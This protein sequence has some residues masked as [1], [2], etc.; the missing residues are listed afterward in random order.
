MKLHN[1]FGIKQTRCT[2]SVPVYMGLVGMEKQNSWT[3][4]RPKN[5]EV[6]EGTKKE[7]T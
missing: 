2:N 1:A 4:N 7:N 6:H 5:N 3:A